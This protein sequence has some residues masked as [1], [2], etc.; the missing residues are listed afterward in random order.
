[1]GYLITEV[2]SSN[3]LVLFHT[4]LMEEQ[5]HL[6]LFNLSTIRRT[7]HLD[8]EK[9]REQAKQDKNSNFWKFEQPECTSLKTFF[10]LNILI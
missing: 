10:F 6:I 4:K 5:N 2:T 7:V 1:M 9:T 3:D 8:E